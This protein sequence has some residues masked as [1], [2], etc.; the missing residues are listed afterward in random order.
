MNI[1]STQYQVV[2]NGAVVRRGNLRQCWLYVL[3]TNAED[4]T[5]AALSFKGVYI[6]PAGREDE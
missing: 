6:E 5:A 1:R 2:E 4:T 3:N